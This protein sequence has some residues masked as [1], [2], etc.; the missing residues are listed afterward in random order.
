MCFMCQLLLTSVAVQSSWML[1][2]KNI[3]IYTDKKTEKTEN[4]TEIRIWYQIFLPVLAS[5]SV[6]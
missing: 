6:F 3:Y 5:A 1:G 2:K 4:D